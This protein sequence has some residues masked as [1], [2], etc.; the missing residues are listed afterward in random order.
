MHQSI[1]K[2]NDVVQIISKPYIGCIGYITHVMKTCY[3]V[4]GEGLGV[5]VSHNNVRLCD[6]EYMSS[7]QALPVTNP[8]IL[9]INM[10]IDIQQECLERTTKRI[11]YLKQQLDICDAGGKFDKV[12]WNTK[13]WD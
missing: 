5:A 6:D 1:L 10:L 2:M 9:H 4:D 13:R 3:I 11:T 8:Y 7:D 12:A